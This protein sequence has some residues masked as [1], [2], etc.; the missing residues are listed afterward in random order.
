MARTGARL[1]RHQWRARGEVARRPPPRQE[2]ARRRPETRR[3]LGTR[4][5]RLGRRPAS[6]CSRNSA[7]L[8][9]KRRG[10]SALR[11]LDDGLE[12][13]GPDPTLFATIRHCPLGHA[14]GH[15]GP[16]RTRLAR[17]VYHNTHLEWLHATSEHSC[18]VT[19]RNRSG[20][21]KAGYRPR[22]QPGPRRSNRVPKRVPN[23]A[24]L[25][26]DNRLLLERVWLY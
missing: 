16:A 11:Q 23:S 2:Q 12:A 6:F 22:A 1:R 5:T 15:P 7:A 26:P 10:E 24:I 14:R 8:A 3:M 4:P 25:T 18:A 13:A 9:P 20:T 21:W 17:R 19:V